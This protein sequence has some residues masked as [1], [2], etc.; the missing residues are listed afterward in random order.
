MNFSDKASPSGSLSLAAF[1]ESNLSGY[2]LSAVYNK[3]IEDN[4]ELSDDEKGKL[5]TSSNYLHYQVDPDAVYTE[6]TEDEIIS[7]TQSYLGSAV[8]NAAT[9]AMAFVT[10]VIGAV[11]GY[12]FGRKR[13]KSA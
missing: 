9:W 8:A 2:D 5:K 12:I 13:K 3:S 1:G 11:G 6:S 10:L 7:G 4:F